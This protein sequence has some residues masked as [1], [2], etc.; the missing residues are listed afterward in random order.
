MSRARRPATSI[1]RVL[2]R[3]LLLVVIVPFPPLAYL[4]LAAYR[5]DVDLV[6]AE[7]QETNRQIALLAGNYL[8]SLA[9]TVPAQAPLAALTGPLA[10]ADEQA[11]VRWEVVDAAGIVRASQVAPARVGADAGYPRFLAA[12]AASGGRPV[13]SGVERWIPAMSPTVLL[14]APA[15]PPPAGP[16]PR[17]V[18]VLMPERLHARLTAQLGARLDRRVYVIDAAGR[19]VFYADLELSQRGEDLRDNPPVRRYLEHGAGPLRYA[20]VVSGKERLA[21]VHRSAGF[22]W[23]IVVSTDIGA[24]VLEVRGRYLALLWSIL[25]AL[26]AALGILW[27]TSRRLTVP[28]LRIRDA[29]GRVPAHA[30]LDLPPSALTVAEYAGLV[31]AFNELSARLAT[32]EA[33]LV[34]AEKV[35]LLGQL[36][37]GIAHE[38]GTPLNV[39]SG[40]AQYLKRRLPDADAQATLDKIVG[41]AERLAELIRRVLDF[42]RPAPAQRQAVDLGQVVEQA[43]EL[44]AGALRGLRVATTLAPDAPPVSGNAQLLEHAVA[45]LVLN[46]A[47]ACRCAPG[48]GVISVATVREPG[49]AGGGAGWLACSVT[50]DG[51]GIRPEHLGRIFQPFFT[52]KAQG[53]GTGLGLAL[54]DRIVRQHGGRADVHSAPGVGTVFTLRL[55]CAPAA[56]GPAQRLADAD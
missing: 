6:E 19:L 27:W 14:A 4:S 22:G 32:T 17:L 28:L 5:R 56:A 37:S 8:D 48:G 9:D 53:Q 39:M 47:D 26:V 33:E 23:G 50:D 40:Y 18:A 45:N 25:F 54:V 12:V 3:S 15:A 38:V 31:E 16:A 35:A 11:V 49:P 21:F 24:R 42:A 7:I 20:S 44:C 34:M 1:T 13:V 52:T 36:A 2:V 43:L 29:L 41:Q 51:C 30:P 55:P 10:P 46:A